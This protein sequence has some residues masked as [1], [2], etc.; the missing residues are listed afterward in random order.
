M[1]AAT[2]PFRLIGKRHIFVVSLCNCCIRVVT[3]ILHE[4]VLRV[5]DVDVFEV[6]TGLL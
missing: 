1:G 3:R 4:L 6:L 2:T 5:E